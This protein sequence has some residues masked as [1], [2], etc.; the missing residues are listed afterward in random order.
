MN[1]RSLFLRTFSRP[2]NGV[3][4]QKL[5]KDKVL[6]CGWVGRE[7]HV[8]KFCCK[9]C[10]IVKGF[11]A[12]KIDTKDFSRAEMSQIEGKIVKILG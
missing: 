6:N 11:L 1:L 3:G 7:T 4:V 5:T 8:P 9:F 10:I 2:I 12:T